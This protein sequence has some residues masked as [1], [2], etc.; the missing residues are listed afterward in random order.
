[1]SERSTRNHWV[2]IH[3]TIFFLMGSFSK[4]FFFNDVSILWESLWFGLEE[5]SD[6]ACS[7]SV[8]G[9]ADVEFSLVITYF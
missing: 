9:V 2:L 8:A 5:A 6:T 4:L 1:M 7:T 3:I